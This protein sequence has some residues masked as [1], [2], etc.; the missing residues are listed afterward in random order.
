[1]EAIEAKAT[2]RFGRISARKT[3]LV[4]DLIRGKGV[5]D[6]KKILRFTDKRSATV[7][8]KLLNSAVANAEVKNV[9]DPEILNVA[10]VWVD[11]GPVHKRQ[12]HRARGRVNVIRRPTSHITIVVKEDIEAKEREA[13]RLQALEAKRAKKKA[14]KKKAAGGKKKAETK[15]TET[16]KADKA[17]DKD[18]KAKAKPAAKKKDTAEKAKKVKK[19]TDEGDKK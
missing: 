8:L 9:E 4:A 13:A 10:K 6:A 19:S 18:V 5:E 11:A 17:D 1:M 15:A 14:A 7:M 12:R 3:R 2:L 16:K